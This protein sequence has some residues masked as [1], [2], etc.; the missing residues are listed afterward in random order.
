MPQCN[1]YKQPHFHN[2]QNL[3]NKFNDYVEQIKVRTYEPHS[4]AQQHA[5]QIN[6]RSLFQSL[7][8]INHQFTPRIYAVMNKSGQ[9]HKLK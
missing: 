9:I 8:H 7:K 1:K 3:V 2:T 5:E 4:K 6:N